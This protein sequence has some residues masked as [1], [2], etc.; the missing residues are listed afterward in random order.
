MGHGLGGIRSGNI[1]LLKHLD[2]A[3]RIAATGFSF[4]IFGIGGVLL[5][6]TL[7][8]AIRLVSSDREV[9]RRRVQRAMHWSFRLF[10]WQMCKSG[11]IS[12]ETRN[13]PR[14][15]QPGVLIVANHPSLIDVVLLIAQVPEV[16]CI[17]KIGLWRNPFLRWPVAWADYTPNEGSAEELVDMAAAK[18]RSGRS[19]IVF[20]EGTRSVAGEPLAMQRGAARIAIAAGAPIVPVRISCDQETLTKTKAWYRVPPRR[21]H[22]R[23]EVGEALAPGAFAADGAP[24]SVAARRLTRHFL[25][26]FSVAAPGAR[27]AENTAGVIIA[28]H[29]AH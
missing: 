12:C 8:P 29:A 4:A 14:L 24:P 13:A 7:F 18:L 26:Y 10:V 28:G 5:S 27:T 17:V 2:R 19:L 1:G 25:D 15:L 23:L 21:G 3:W 11:V 16:D 20:P 9:Q 6:L 22:W